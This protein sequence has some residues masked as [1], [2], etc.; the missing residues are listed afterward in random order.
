MSS[1]LEI[2]NKKLELIQ[3]LSTI[4]DLTLL[5]KIADLL[6][7]AQSDWWKE[8]SKE[9]KEAIEK[10]IAEANAGKLKSHSDA[11]AIYGKWL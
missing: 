3:C 4:D 2:Q 1:K 8:T 9:R 5:D 11:R 7:H 10:G 6:S